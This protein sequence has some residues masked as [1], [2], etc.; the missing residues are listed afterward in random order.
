MTLFCRG[1]EW[2]DFF[3]S[4]LS[5]SCTV[6]GAADSFSPYTKAEKTDCGILDFDVLS[7]DRPKAELASQDTAVAFAFDA[8]FADC[9]YTVSFIAA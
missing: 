8:D 4:H 9:T 7:P 3:C 6:G 2:Y 1:V 5:L